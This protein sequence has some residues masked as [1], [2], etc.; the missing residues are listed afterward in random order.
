MRVLITFLLLTGCAGANHLGNPVT[1]PFRAVFAGIEN[2]SYAHRRKAVKDYISTYETEMKAANFKDA[3]TKN[4]LS[5]I[6]PE[7]Q[8]KIR[9]E[10]KESANR[11]DFAEFA[12]IIVM[13]HLS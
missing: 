2:A 8:V 11:S 10:L 5:S 6:A 12:T 13:V 4:L 1:L 7:T 9:E 3:Y